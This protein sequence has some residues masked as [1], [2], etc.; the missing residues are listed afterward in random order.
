MFYQA[1][2]PR[3]KNWTVGAA[4]IH[5]KVILTRTKRWGLT[6][7]TLWP[8]WPPNFFNKSLIT[9]QPGEVFSTKKIIIIK[10]SSP[11][12]FSRP[13]KKNIYPCERKAKSPCTCGLVFTNNEQSTML[14]QHAMIWQWLY[15][16]YIHILIHIHFLSSSFTLI[17]LAHFS[18][19]YSQISIISKFTYFDP[20]MFFSFVWHMI[21][22]KIFDLKFSHWKRIDNTH[23]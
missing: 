14:I 18:Y 7:Y 15:D 2:R 16:L 23:Y 22:G 21:I 5:K 10:I 19:I 11:P 3:I 17:S 20:K 8:S 4:S 12:F 13:K 9:T 6:P 1:S